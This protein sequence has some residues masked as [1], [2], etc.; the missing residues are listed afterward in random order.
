MVLGEAL[1]GLPSEDK[2]KRQEADMLIAQY[3]YRREFGLSYEQWCE[4]PYSSFLAN[5]AIMIISK[6][7][8][9][10]GK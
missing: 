9:S 1:Y 4:E 5:M 10:G 8:Q 2:E 7:A 3:F 6:Q